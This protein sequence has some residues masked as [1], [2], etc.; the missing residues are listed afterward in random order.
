MFCTSS[1]QLI[2][3]TPHPFFAHFSSS[4]G[5]IHSVILCCGHKLP[6]EAEK[7]SDTMIMGR[8]SGRWSDQGTLL[9]EV[10][11]SAQVEAAD[12]PILTPH[13]WKNWPHKATP[14]QQQRWQVI[15]S[16]EIRG[17]RRQQ[18]GWAWVTS[19]KTLA[20]VSAIRTLCWL[21]KN[22]EGLWRHRGCPF[23]CTQHP[24]YIPMQYEQHYGSG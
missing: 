17:L 1:C 19:L 7:D 14:D 23:L 8:M 22:E 15:G 11:F 12:L 9:W 13:S 4:L 6:V 3:H 10:H 24:V 2:H 18:G 21:P 16:W 5:G 20:V